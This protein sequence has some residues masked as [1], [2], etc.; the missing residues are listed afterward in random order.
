MATRIG[1]PMVGATIPPCTWASMRSPLVLNLFN[2]GQSYTRFSRAYPL[3]AESP[4]KFFKW[5]AGYLFRRGAYRGPGGGG[6]QEPNFG[7]FNIDDTFTYFQVGLANP[8]EKA[9]D[10]K[11]FNQ[12]VGEV[13]DTDIGTYTITSDAHGPGIAGQ[14]LRDTSPGGTEIYDIGKLTGF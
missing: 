1:G 5:D 8:I 2:W 11:D 12:L 10:N 13:V 3:S 9:V 6:G 4:P 7:I 14:L